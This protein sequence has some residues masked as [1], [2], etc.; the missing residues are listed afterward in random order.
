MPFLQL[1][2]RT[3]HRDFMGTIKPSNSCTTLFS[4]MIVS[5]SPKLFIT[6]SF[7]L[8]IAPPTRVRKAYCTHYPR[9][10]STTDNGLDDIVC[11]SEMKPQEHQRTMKHQSTAQLITLN[12]RPNMPNLHSSSD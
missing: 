4:L 6:R 9:T 5:F 12:F 1:R 7:S 10:Q 11:T 2:H 8:K 3:L